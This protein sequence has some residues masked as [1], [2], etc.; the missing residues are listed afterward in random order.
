MKRVFLYAFVAGLSLVLA[1]Q[2]ASAIPSGWTST[3]H[4]YN[5][6]EKMGQENDWKAE[7]VDALN[8]YYTFDT[9]YKLESGAMGTFYGGEVFYGSGDD[10]SGASITVTHDDSTGFSG[11]WAT[12][13][14]LIGY[15][16]KASGGF[17][18][19]GLIPEAS[20]GDWDLGDLHA[21]LAT[22]PDGNPKADISHLWGFYAD[23]TKV[24]EP[25]TVL[26]LGAG[27]I[28]LAG[29]RRKIKK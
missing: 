17:K 8:D 16:I 20:S 2:V 9:L 13:R 1:V 23:T 28:G 5:I 3:P 18:L 29:F 22:Q 12:N 19:Y 25:T 27:L 10:D 7:I 15:S 11:T 26:L 4:G 21:F 6:F 24:P 14:N